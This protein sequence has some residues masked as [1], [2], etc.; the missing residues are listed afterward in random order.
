MATKHNGPL[1]GDILRHIKAAK[2]VGAP[3]IATNI[4]GAIIA[5]PFD[6][7]YLDKLAQGQPPVPDAKAPEEGHNWKNW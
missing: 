6:S 4:G 3:G 7:A 5:I 2:K 1:L